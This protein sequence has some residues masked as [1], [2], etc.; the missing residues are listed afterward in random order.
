MNTFQVSMI[1]TWI[2]HQMPFEYLCLY[3]A[4]PVWTEPAGVQPFVYALILFGTDSG[5]RRI[6]LSLCCQH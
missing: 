1:E 6:N 5:A 4:H 2:I 3:V